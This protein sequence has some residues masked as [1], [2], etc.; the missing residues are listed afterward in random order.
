MIEFQVNIDK[1][2]IKDIATIDKA[3]TGEAGSF[4]AAIEVI[5]RVSDLDTT[6]VS[7]KHMKEVF[8]VFT[9]QISEAINPEN[10]S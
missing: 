4:S 9:N 7:I 10:L 3:A 5:D 2:T 8:E 6:E 1:L